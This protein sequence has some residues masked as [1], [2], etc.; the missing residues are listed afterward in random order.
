[1][2]NDE[3]LAIRELVAE[4]DEQRVDA[5]FE[6]VSID[7]S[8]FRDFLDILRSIEEVEGSFYYEDKHEEYDVIVFEG[9]QVEAPAHLIK[10]ITDLAII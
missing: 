4:N 1:M 9:V 7:K 10:E 6:N 3:M 2:T 8:D 5:D